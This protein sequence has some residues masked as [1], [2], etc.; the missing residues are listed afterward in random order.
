MARRDA[1]ME[2]QIGQS[3]KRCPAATTLLVNEHPA[4]VSGPEVKSNR[5]VST[6]QHKALF[7]LQKSRFKIQA[8]FFQA[9]GI[10]CLHPGQGLTHP[11]VQLQHNSRT[12]FSQTTIL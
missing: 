8:T 1:R 2:T 12:G 7:G 11:L 3:T 4:G 10:N 6:F 5:Q 9:R